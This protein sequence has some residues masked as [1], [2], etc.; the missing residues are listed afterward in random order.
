MGSKNMSEKP[1]KS[2]DE[3][4]DAHLRWSNVSEL[5]DLLDKVFVDYGQENDMTFMEMDLVIYMLNEKIF[6]Q[7]VFTLGMGDTGTVGINGSSGMYR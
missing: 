4:E 1:D 3:K 5:F 6:Q 2:K 7:K